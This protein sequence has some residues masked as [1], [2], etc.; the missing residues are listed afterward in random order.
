MSSETAARTSKRAPRFG[1]STSGGSAP[2]RNR[3]PPTRKF[4]ASRKFRAISERYRLERRLG[5]GSSATV[6]LARDTKTGRRVAVK[7]FYPHLVADPDARERISREARA[8]QLLSHPSIISAIDTISTDT[9][10]ALVFPFVAGATLSERLDAGAPL[11]ARE[12]AAIATD[13]AD[14]LTVAHDAGLIHRDVKP[15]NILVAA[16][17]RARLL[18]FGIS[19]TLSSDL[20]STHELTGPGM[21]AGTLPYMAPE[22]L[23]AEAPTPATDVYALG[24]VLYEMLAGSRPFRAA[25]PLELAIEQHVAPARIERQPPELVHQV[26]TA[27]AVAPAD[28]PSAIQFARS[29]RGWLDGRADAN[30][31]TTV[32]PAGPAAAA[33]AV[34]LDPEI[35]APAAAAAPAVAA[36]SL[37]MSGL[38]RRPSRVAGAVAGGGLALAVTALLAFAPHPDPA[39]VGNDHATPAAEATASPDGR[40]QSAPLVP[41]DEQ[42]MSGREEV[43]HVKANEDHDEKDKDKDKGE[44]EGGGD[45]KGGDR[46]RR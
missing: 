5:S 32:V 42:R 22:Q 17:R 4:R 31:Q 25:S 1:S 14:A 6:W 11:A 12:A 44:R 41:S 28:R 16:D 29:L 40:Q 33:P 18:D 35:A 34:A 43:K 8:A 36:A 21:T 26:M 39:R 7:S 37:S 27:L 20:E 38:L 3:E 24:V 46:G 30:E 23:T 10:M 2:D 9:E 13:I 15:A 45:G 19:R